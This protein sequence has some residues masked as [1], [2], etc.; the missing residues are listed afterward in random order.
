MNIIRNIL[1]KIRGEQSLDRL[2]KRGLVIG[3]NVTIMGGCIIDPSHCWHI[4]IGSDVILAPRVHIIAHDA[5]TK[6][7]MGFTKVANVTIGNRVFIGA[8]TVVLPGVTIGD[9]VV[10]G[11]GTVVNKDIPSGSVAAGVPVRIVSS[12]ADYIDKEKEKKRVENSFSDDY[13]LRNENFSAEQINVLRE[14]CE[15]YGQIFVE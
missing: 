3:D 10:I 7:F 15:K 13:T 6:L 14:A 11:A 1:K 4:R 2:K 9:D 5:S 12:L 8:G